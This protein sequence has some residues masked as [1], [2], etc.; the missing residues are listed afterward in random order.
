MFPINKL[1]LKGAILFFAI[2]LV[3]LTI[4]FLGY[5]DLPINN[6]FFTPGFSYNKFQKI[7]NGMTEEQ[8]NMLLGIPYSI[9][10]S[11]DINNPGKEWN[12]STT[13]G[14]G[15]FNGASLS[16]SDKFF[17]IRSIGVFFDNNQRVKGRFDH[18]LYILTTFY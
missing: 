7:Q 17:G 15:T 9:L 6:P 8:V 16:E 12:Y 13:G 1:L 4:L 5:L 10:L 14:K 3:L 2:A 18:K 11:G